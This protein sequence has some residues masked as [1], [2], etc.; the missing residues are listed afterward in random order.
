M[1]PWR[2]I[3]VKDKTVIKN[4]V[5]KAFSETNQKAS[6]APVL[7]VAC[8]N[9]NDDIVRDGKEYYLFDLGLTIENMLLAATALGLVTH[10]MAGLDHNELCKTLG[11]PGDVQ[12]VVATPVAYPAEGSYEQAVQARLGERTRK[13]LEELVYSDTWGRQF[14]G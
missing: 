8:A 12:F 2:F 9:P 10:L 3:V 11:I 13:S 1:Q 14:N 7:I 4:L 5:T 6:E